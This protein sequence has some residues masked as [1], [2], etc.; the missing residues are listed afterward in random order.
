[1]TLDEQFY[2]VW[3]YVYISSSLLETDS[4]FLANEEL[5]TFTICDKWY[6]LSKH[7]SAH[8]DGIGIRL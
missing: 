3:E 2:I 5:Y 4:L 1:M 7:V 6:C 8:C